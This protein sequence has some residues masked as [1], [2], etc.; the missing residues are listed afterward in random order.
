M[1]PRKPTKLPKVI[2]RSEAQR[3]LSLPDVKCPTGLRNRVALQLMYRAGLR[4]GEVCNLG[5]D[6]IDLERGYIYVQLGKGKRDRVVPTDPDTLAW[7]RRWMECRPPSRYFICTLKGGRLSDRYLRQVLER[8]SRKAAIY[9]NSS[10]SQ[11]PVHPHTLRHCFATERL[12]DGFSIVEVQ[13]LLGHSSIQTTQVYTA[14]RPEALRS[15]MAQ[16][17]PVGKSH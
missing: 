6:D 17:P 7:C 14:V 11:R 3:L 5:P 12:E 13:E 2:S 16:L 10:H 1:A 4:V 9:L 15:K 8:L